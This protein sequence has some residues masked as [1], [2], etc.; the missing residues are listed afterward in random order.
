MKQPVTVV[1]ITVPT[2]AVTEQNGSTVEVFIG[3]LVVRSGPKGYADR[4]AALVMSSSQ[5][6]ALVYNLAAKLGMT[7][8]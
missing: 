5:A 2:V 3:R 7:V 8:S 4:H 1:P 6:E